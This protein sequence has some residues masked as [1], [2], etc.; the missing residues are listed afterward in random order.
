M[1][2]R[3]SACASRRIPPPD[4]L[5]PAGRFRERPGSFPA[6]QPTAG[7]AR[8]ALHRSS[9]PGSRP[10]PASGGTSCAVR[11]L[12]IRD[13]APAAAVGLALVVQRGG[14]SCA[15]T[16]ASAARG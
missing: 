14:G 4:R 1:T 16:Q 15:G 13:H 11:S 12:D 7:G 6:C 3:S 9:A 10:K 5:S 2:G 8:T